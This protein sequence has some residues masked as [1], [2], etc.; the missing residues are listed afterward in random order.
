MNEEATLKKAE[1]PS[2]E[3]YYL[4]IAKAV[5]ER[6]TCLRRQYGAVIV[7]HD[8][9]VSTGYNGSPRGEE[10]CCDKG[11]CHREAMNL[12]HGK[13]YDSSC[14]AVHAENNAIIQANP[15]DLKDSVL[16]LYGSENGN[17]IESE[18]CE[19]CKRIIKNAGISK[20]IGSSRMSEYVILNF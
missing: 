3:N 11:Y 9:I 8:R 18:P 17:P 16:Y 5:S 4:G 14:P 10:N 13:C 1:R 7:K 19:M 6:S 20:V 15:Q 2:K 12:P